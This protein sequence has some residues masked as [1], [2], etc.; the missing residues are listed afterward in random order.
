MPNYGVLGPDNKIMTVIVAEDLETAQNFFKGYTVHPEEIATEA[1][2]PGIGWY[3]DG[4]KFIAPWDMPAEN[5][6][7]DATITDESG[8]TTVSE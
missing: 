4:E 3:F 2:N 6:K 7:S 5:T 1:G 8:T